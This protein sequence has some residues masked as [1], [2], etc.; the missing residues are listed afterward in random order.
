MKVQVNQGGFKRNCAHQ[1]LIYADNVN[2]LGK[3]VNTIKKNPPQLVVSGK[4]IRL[5]INA[6]KNKYMVMSG[7]Q[8]A[9]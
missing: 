2:V 7:D 3:S 1:V 8:N 4:E 9:G 6:D 5:E